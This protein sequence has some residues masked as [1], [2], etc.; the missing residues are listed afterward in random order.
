V[1]LQENYVNATRAIIKTAMAYAEYQEEEFADFKINPKGRVG[2]IR[3]PDTVT[4]TDENGPGTLP[5]PREDGISSEGQPIPQLPYEASNQAF[6]TEQAPF[7]RGGI[8][9][10]LPA[11]VAKKPATL[12]AFDTIVLADVIAPVDAKGRTYSVARYVDALRSWVERGGNLVLTDRAIYALA[13]MGVVAPETVTDV[14]V[15]LPYANFVDFEH[16]MLDGLRANARQLA[17]TTLVGYEIDDNQ[18]EESGRMTVV[19]RAAFEE[20]GGHTVGTTGDYE[21]SDDDGTSTSVG[22]LELGDGVIRIT[23]GLPMPTESNDH[24]FGLKDYALTYSGLFILENS[25]VHDAPNL[26][27]RPTRDGSPQRTRGAALILF[28]LLPLAAVAARRRV[29]G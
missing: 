2:Y 16:P 1:L 12:N 13:D 24:R 5:G 23:G 8:T 15:Y 29:R 25:I 6:F 7:V 3:N 27:G 21:G 20:A 19:D 4:D 14:E 10:V 9:P 26:G 22:E 18:G 17:E 11:D 28:G